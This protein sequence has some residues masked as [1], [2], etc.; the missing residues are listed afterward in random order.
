MQRNRHAT[1]LCGL[2]CVVLNSACTGRAPEAARA[3]LLKPFCVMHVDGGAIK[4]PM[5]ER[6]V[7]HGVNLP[8]ISALESAGES[9]PARIDALAADGAAVIRM[10]VVEREVTPGFVPDKLLPAVIRANENGVVLILSWQNDPTVKLNAQADAA[11]DFV[12]L[13]VPALRGF[14]GVWLDPLNVPLDQPEGKRRAVAERMLNVVRGLGDGRIV[15][16]NNADWLRSAD[17]DLRKPFEHPNVVYGVSA[18]DAFGSAATLPLFLS[19]PRDAAA[20]D[21]AVAAG[22]GSTAVD[23]EQSAAWASSLR[24]RRP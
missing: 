13:L 8:S 19:A 10:A 16:I 3:P 4:G 14:D 5:G 18:I 24:C 21:A 15:V 12:R 11:E 23:A 20:R 1:V 6:I 22:I 2:L 17:A 7:L 9:A